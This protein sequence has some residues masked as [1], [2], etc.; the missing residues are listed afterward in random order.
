MFFGRL[1]TYRFV[2][3]S[4]LRVLRRELWDGCSWLRPSMACSGVC[5]YLCK[6]GLVTAEEKATNAIL[7]INIVIILYKSVPKMGQ[8]LYPTPLNAL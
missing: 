2:L 7:C 4:L 8:T 3:S 1:D 6:F 5:N